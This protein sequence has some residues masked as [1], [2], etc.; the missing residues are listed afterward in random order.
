[1]VDHFGSSGRESVKMVRHDY[2][3]PRG[4]V[5]CFVLFCFVL[6]CFVFYNIRL[7]ESERFPLFSIYLNVE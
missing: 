5:A 6:F 4:G 1:M 3:F 2:C 7:P